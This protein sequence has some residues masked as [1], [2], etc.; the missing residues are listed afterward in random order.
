MRYTTLFI[1]VLACA[2][3][4]FS[5]VTA[6]PL[7]FVER[8]PGPCRCTSHPKACRPVTLC[9]STL[10]PERSLDQREARTSTLA[11]YGPL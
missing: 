8:A 11:T 2:A 1:A 9:F 5:T 10:E 3:S 4:M 6:T 7:E